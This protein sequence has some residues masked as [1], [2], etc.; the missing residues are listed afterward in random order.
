MIRKPVINVPGCPPIADVM[1]AVITHILVLGK[2]PALDPPGPAQGG[3]TG[4]AY[5]TCY[6]RP[7]YDGL[8][9]ESRLTRMHAKAIASTKWVARG[10]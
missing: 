7:N 6:R 1:M 4:A 3:F 5:T 2:M 9:V 10:L 8:F